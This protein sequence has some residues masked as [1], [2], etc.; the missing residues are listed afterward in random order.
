MLTHLLFAASESVSTDAG[1]AVANA[2]RKMHVEDVLLPV[3]IQIA[4]I[5]AVARVFSLLFRKLG[6]SGVVGEI[7]AGLMLGPSLFGRFFP[8][9]WA[10]IFHP[11]PHDTAVS[12]ALFDATL[13]WVFTVLSQIGL[14]LLLF[15]VGLEFDFQHLKK[16]GRSA[17][18]ISLSGLL[19][20]IGLG[21]GLAVWM[22]PRLGID[23]DL[24]AA[25]PF[26]G[27]VL[28]LG[29]AMSITALPILGRLMM[30]LNITRTR[31][32]AIT[33]TSAAID[34]VSGWILLATVS[35]IVAGNFEVGL[36]LRML[37]GTIAFAALML[38]VVRPLFLRF[39]RSVV[40]DGEL[41]LNGL[42]GTLLCVLVC[43]LATNLIGIFSIFGAFLFG[44]VLSTEHEYREAVIKRLRDL[45]AVFFLPIFFTYTGLRTD[46][47]TVSTPELWLMC[48]LVLAAAVVGKF[49]GC[50]LAAWAS[51]FTPRESACI[52]IMMNTRALME[53]IV[54]NVGY[55]LG[56]IPKS[57][58]CMLVLMALI[59][60]VM[61][62]PILLRLMRGTE[63]EPWINQSIFR[64]G[65]GVLLSSAS[66]DTPLV[67]TEPAAAK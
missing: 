59:T 16:N 35:A 36:T 11:L 45:V 48:G 61:T 19:L 20:P 9:T 41:T 44:A 26:L 52:G 38:L 34:D 43:S 12:A 6:Q 42:A 14:I 50:G 56:V 4:I 47:Q 21:M 2:L 32:G 54:I 60:T 10:K 22:H 23:P 51:G 58:F 25:P 66:I 46:V 33:I 28:F 18:L 17:V 67:S 63:L 30:E 5:I 7:A 3:V 8:E 24:G 39:A 40:V 15:L 53:L 27:F 55:Q 13:H 64:K 31:V 49:G 1:T 65:E 29:T 62:T 57:V 37:G